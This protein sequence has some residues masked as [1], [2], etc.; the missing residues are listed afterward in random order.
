MGAQGRLAPYG[1]SFGQQ[2]AYLGL[3]IFE[4]TEYQRARLA[5]FHTGRHLAA[6]QAFVTESALLDYTADAETLGKNI[7]DDLAEG[8]PTLP[9]I[10]GRQLLDA[11]G[12]ALI[13]E[14]IREGGIERIGEIVE[15]IR[16]CGA[17]AQTREAARQRAEAA[18]EAIAPLPDSE[19]KDAMETLASYSIS[20]SY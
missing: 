16:A 12:R 17:L 2:L 5:G 11:E 1:V 7:G 15:M 3:G 19:W 4:I 9:L 20:R 10:L 8:K 18:R 13:D 14:T 6:N